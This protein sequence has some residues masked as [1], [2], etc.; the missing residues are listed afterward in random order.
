MKKQTFRGVVKRRRVAV[1]SKSEHDAV[2]LDQG[3]GGC[4]E[5]RLKNGNPFHELALD[6]LVGKT[7]E[8]EGI[9]LSGLPHIFIEK[10]TDIK[11]LPP[12]KHGA[13]RKPPKPPRM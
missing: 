7:V 2:V 13:A 3:Y 8:L 12:P 5:L 4:L 10:L 6:A 1:G 9:P 11:I